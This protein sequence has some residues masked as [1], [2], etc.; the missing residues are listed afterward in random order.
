MLSFGNSSRFNRGSERKNRLVP[1]PWSPLDRAP[2]QN[3]VKQATVIQ[4][5]RS[6]DPQVTVLI[7]I[8]D[9]VTFLDAFLQSLARQTYN[10][11]VVLIGLRNKDSSTKDT[12]KDIVA[13]LQLENSVDYNDLSDSLS[14][15]ESYMESAK[16]AKTP[17]VA[18]ARQIDLWVSRKLE[19]QLAALNEEPDLGLVGTMSRLFGDKVELVNAPPGKLNKDDFKKTNPIIFS[20]VVIKRELLNFT[21]EFKSYDFESWLKLNREGV[22]I[23]N[24][25][26]ILTLQRNSSQ[27]QPRIEDR[28][29][30]I[31]KYAEQAQ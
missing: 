22:K 9:D 20:S 21:K 23:V 14:E 24:L 1:E 10:K 31:K 7:D 3:I 25:T 30:V 16:L 12:V 15:E 13:K 2:T 4:L 5:Q 17:Y 8:K 11:W 29:K 28:E 19:K 18:L 26:D 27:L 6:Q